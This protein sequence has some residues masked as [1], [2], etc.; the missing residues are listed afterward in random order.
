MNN[1]ETLIVGQGIAGTCLAWELR[2]RGR[3]F[4]IVDPGEPRTAS[5]VA[6]GLITPV[7]GKRFSV[8]PHFDDLYARAKAAYSAVEEQLGRQVL[9]PQPAL[10]LCFSAE[11]AAFFEQRASRLEELGRAYRMAGT[12]D[13]RYRQYLC[14]VLMPEAAR[15]DTGV[16]LEQ[17][18][19]FLSEQGQWLSARVESSALS[20]TADSVYVETLNLRARNVV[21]CGGYQDQSNAWLPPDVFNS[22]KGEILTV[23]IPGLQEGRTIH[24]QKSWLCPTGE[25]DVYRFGATYEHDGYSDRIT[26]RARELLED[27]LTS[28]L[29]L[30]FQTIDH[31]YGIRPVGMQRKA[32]VGRSTRAPNVAWLNGLGSKG[33]LLAPYLASCLVDSLESNTPVSISLADAHTHG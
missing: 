25:S 23:T 24:A 20:V 8:A 17:S 22:A 14:A 16:F 7:S 29:S 28:I 11:E 27:R 33:S 6:A 15:L 21:F 32:I 9:L 26:G 4:L 12:V 13:S 1:V 30:P 18:R 5:K 19:R 10:R 2:K 3:D 31:S